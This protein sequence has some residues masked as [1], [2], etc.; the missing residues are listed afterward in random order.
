MGARTGPND[1]S[2]F[3]GGSCFEGS[4]TH[5]RAAWAAVRIDQHAM[6]IKS[7]WGVVDLDME[8]SANTVEH[9]G[10]LNAMVEAETV[11]SFVRD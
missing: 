2:A 6:E 7:L 11:C 8:Q 9:F 1:G 3:H 5:P 10:F 4:S